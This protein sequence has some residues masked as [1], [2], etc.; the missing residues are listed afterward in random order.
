M[1]QKIAK[2]IQQGVS[3]P[4]YVLY[5]TE[6][7]LV[8]EMLTHMKEHILGE[9]AD[10]FNFASFDLEREPIE[11][12][13]QEAETLPFIGDKRL[14]IGRNAWFLTGSKGKTEVNHDL[15]ALAAY[16]QTPLDSS[17]VVLVVP[18]SKL[19][20]RKKL[21]KEIK[22]QGVIVDCEPLKP[23]ALRTWIKRAVARYGADIAPEA[24]EGLV[25]KVGND[26]RL[27]RQECHKLATY[28]GEGGSIALNHV[29]K[30]IPRSLEDNVF[31]LIDE[32]GKMNIAGALDIFYDLVK[33]R[34][35]PI[36]ILALMARQFRIIL[37]VKE[38]NARGYSQKQAA[39]TLG[40]HPYP[41][42][43]A[44]QQGQLFSERSLQKL[45]LEA[46]RTDYAIKSG[47]K[48]KTLAVEWYLLSM[49]Q[50]VRA[51]HEP[52]TKDMS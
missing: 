19:D 15:K 30:M 52:R 14:I 7:Y 49:K 41:V 11:T 33:K 9:G 45:L 10:D 31:K 4:L 21:V 38:L 23:A 13:I 18:H 24:I 28:V 47:Q 42:K 34:E 39:S 36:K 32:M 26:L 46:N 5:G 44:A 37:Q 3:S 27:L 8:E 48:E 35:E 6:T 50:W 22:K 40:L 29:E 16:I 2:Q 25:Q 43:I 20:A 12:L 51:S 1:I 17:I